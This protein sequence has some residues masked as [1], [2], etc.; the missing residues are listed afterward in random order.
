MT[1]SPL[2]A[3]T[4]LGQIEDLELLG[5][6]GTIQKRLNGQ[7]SD[8]QFAIEDAVVLAVIDREIDHVYAWVGDA[9]IQQR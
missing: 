1:E 6:Q 5:V 4:L 2:T 9:V 7:S 3:Y 8:P